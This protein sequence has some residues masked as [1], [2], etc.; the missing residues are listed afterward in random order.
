MAAVNGNMSLL[1]LEHFANGALSKANASA[2]GVE[3]G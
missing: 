1:G 2:A 3:R